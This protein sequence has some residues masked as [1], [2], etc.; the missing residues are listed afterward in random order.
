MILQNFCTSVIN[1]IILCA[2]FSDSLCQTANGLRRATDDNYDDDDDDNNN[3]NYRIDGECTR[4]ERGGNDDDDGRPYTTRALT[5]IEN[6][7]RFY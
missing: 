4:F 5:L 6:K 7:K 3:N 1:I 2:K